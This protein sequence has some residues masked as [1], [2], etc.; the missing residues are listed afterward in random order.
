MGRDSV[1]HEEG[2]DDE[3]SLQICDV[4]GPSSRHFIT[5]SLLARKQFF[6]CEHYFLHLAR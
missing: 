5:D 1:K 2:V 3:K 6:L 4:E